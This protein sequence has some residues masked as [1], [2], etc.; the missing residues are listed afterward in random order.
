[1]LPALGR[2]AQ[3]NLELVRAAPRLPPPWPCPAP[4]AGLPARLLPAVGRRA[5]LLLPP[6][7]PQSRL[8][9]L[10]LRA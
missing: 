2:R 9:L 4:L 6:V 1:M 7:L 5:Q 10:A 8:Q 3:F